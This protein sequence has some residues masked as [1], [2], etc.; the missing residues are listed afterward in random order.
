MEKDTADNFLESVIYQL[1]SYKRMAEKAIDQISDEQL[2]WQKDSNSL[3]IA[4]IMKHLPT[5]C[6]A[7]RSCPSLLYAI[8]IQPRCRGITDLF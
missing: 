4:T 6:C 7:F 2:R 3:S 8:A 5:N 1:E